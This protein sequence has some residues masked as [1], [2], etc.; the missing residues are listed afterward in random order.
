MMV[1]GSS[2]DRWKAGPER[3]HTG[4]LWGRCL[5]KDKTDRISNVSEQTDTLTLRRRVGGV[6]KGQIYGK[7][8]T[9]TIRL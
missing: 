6:N 2:D 3:T 4:G 8:V 7:L 9:K 1:E 5:W